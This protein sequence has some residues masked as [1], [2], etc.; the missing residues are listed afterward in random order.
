MKNLLITSIC[1][2]ISSFCFAQ[3]TDLS[4][5]TVF[6]GEPYLAIDPSNPQHMIVAWMG[7]VYGT[8]L[9]IKL[10]ATFNGGKAWSNTVALPHISPT[11]TSADPS[12]AFD[13]LGN[14]YACYIDYRQSPDSGGVYTSK[15]ADGG[16][17]WS[18]PNLVINV[19]SDGKEEP[20]DRPWLTIRQSKNS[21][22][23]TMYVTTKPAPWIAPPVRPYLSK[24]YN[25]GVSWQPW[26]Y[27]DTIGY[28]VGN[29]LAGPMA[30]PAIDSSGKFHCVYPAYYSPESVY[31][32]YIMATLAM[33]THLT[34]SVAVSN[35]GTA[36]DTLAKAGGRLICD[37]KNNGHYGFF[38]LQNT[39]SG[40]DTDID[41]KFAETYNGGSTW[42]SQ[43][44]VNDDPIGNGKM[45]DLVW[46]NFDEKG[47]IIAAW[48][49][50]RNA[51]GGGYQQPSEIWGAIKWKDSAAF[52]ANYRIS[53]TIV[54]YNNAYLSIAGNDFMNVGMH[55]DTMSAIWGDVRTGVLNIWFVHKSMLTKT[56]KTKAMKLVSEHIP[57]VNIYPNPVG[58]SFTLQGEGIEA[59][60]LYDMSGKRVLEQ[61]I[62]NSLTVINMPHLA[63]GIYP[64]LVK[65]KLGIVSLKVVKK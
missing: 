65:T 1:I 19:F 55:Q 38:S 62:H 59:I 25:Y 10:K 13:H 57:E 11:Y 16:L 12:I 18:T 51:P 42:S 40:K 43:V 54:A 48:R 2:F 22:P 63:S 5:G 27:I 26:R 8:E 3:D 6:E 17:T 33:P 50:R 49:D 35:A 47:D 31:P 39:V 60:E 21:K 34:Y 29:I 4:D 9:N 23:D 30:A 36:L 41:V 14:A 37:P 45:Q 24:S 64:A 52:S 44:R 46:A 53:D 32:R 15:S 28:Q 58:S 56:K 7:W 61:T 20:I